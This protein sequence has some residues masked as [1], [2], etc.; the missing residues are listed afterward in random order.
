MSPNN[1]TNPNAE[2]DERDIV[3]SQGD[4]SEFGTDLYDA[5]T[6]LS[7]GP[8][9]IGIPPIA[10]RTTSPEVDP[11]K[12]TAAPKKRRSVV[13]PKT[14]SAPAAPSS[15][16][17]PEADISDDALA[18]LRETAELLHI[19]NRDA[20]QE[21]A[22]TL[23]KFNSALKQGHSLTS[24]IAGVETEGTNV[25][26]VCYEGTV[27]VRIPIRESF[28][29]VPESLLKDTLPNTLRRQMQF[30]SKAI[31]AEISFVL[32]SYRADPDGAGDVFYASRTQ[33]L[34]RQRRT[35][36]GRNASR[37]LKPGMDI[38]A[39]IICMSSYVLYLSCCGLDI[40]VA[41][42][43]LSH[44]YIPDM[45]AKY[46]VGQ[47]IR[48]RIVDVNDAEPDQN[49]SLTVSGRLCELDSL[50][51]N[52]KRLRFPKN[53]SS[54]QHPRFMGTVTSLTRERNS[55]TPRVV[56]SL[57]LDGIELPAFS[58]TLNL[59]LEDKLHTGD[60][61]YFECHGY[62][63]SGYVHGS[64]VRFVRSLH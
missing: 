39:Q 51:P 55:D 38:Y 50:R 56:I 48:V 25:Y 42:Y 1:P 58:R 63:P 53:Q 35:F 43:Q 45:S 19:E 4:D 47:T 18:V 37:P 3:A 11:E 33:A 5:D 22:T 15:N 62:T 44:R 29:I 30:L 40:R 24:T 20:R 23:A 14:A 49:P 13:A 32:T 36:F 64:I 54:S 2:L 8:A 52:L 21:D 9:E 28:M 60:K 17:E 41:N 27:T 61:V 16:M 6:S 10:V 12:E 34:R 26:W 7:E 46:Y 31:G 57:F 59:R